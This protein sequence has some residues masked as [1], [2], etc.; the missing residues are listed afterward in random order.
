VVYGSRLVPDLRDFAGAC[1]AFSGA[2]LANGKSEALRHR[3]MLGAI[4]KSKQD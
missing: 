2:A 1:I 3:E 4:D